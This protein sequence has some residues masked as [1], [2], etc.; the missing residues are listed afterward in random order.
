MARP[1]QNGEEQQVGSEPWRERARDET[2]QAHLGSSQPSSSQAGSGSGRAKH[3]RRS[4]QQRQRQRPCLGDPTK[5][6]GGREVCVSLPWQ[7][8]S[9]QLLLCS[10]SM[11]SDSKVMV[12]VTHP[13]GSDRARSI[14]LS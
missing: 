10:L 7:S 6:W 5:R 12:R 9:T 3:G 8:L 11:P 1:E 13:V 4:G 2:H 14:Q